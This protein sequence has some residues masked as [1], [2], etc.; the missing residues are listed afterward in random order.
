MPDYVE[1]LNAA[2]GPIGSIA[3]RSDIRASHRGLGAAFTMDRVWTS[4]YTLGL[5]RFA[6]QPDY[7]A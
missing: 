6:G 3:R 5:T 7:A 2:L 1:R 4:S